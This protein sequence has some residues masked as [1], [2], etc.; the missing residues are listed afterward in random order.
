M[1]A[2]TEVREPQ[3]NGA[4]A[5]DDAIRPMCKPKLFRPSVPERL[6]FTDCLLDCKP[7]KNSRKFATVLSFTVQCL[8]IGTFIIVP[9]MFT[10]ALSKQQLLTFLVAPSPPPPPPPPAVAATV[11]AVRVVQSD[12]LSSGQLRTPSRIPEKVQL[13]REEEAPLS[14]PSIGG[15]VGDV[16]GG[17][18]G[19]QLGGVIGGIISQRSSARMDS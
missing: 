13:I 6:L 19:G 3:V 11:K 4:I 9:L 15:V 8:L 14:L 7:G 2:A 18:P 17:V 10:A 12:L 1:P 5:V 16:P